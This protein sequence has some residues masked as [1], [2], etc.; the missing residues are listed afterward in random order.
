M[1]TKWF[2]NLGSES[3]SNPRRLGSGGSQEG[4][5]GWISAF[6][7]P[8]SS[9]MGCNFSL[10]EKREPLVK[11]FRSQRSLCGYGWFVEYPVKGPKLSKHIHTIKTSYII[12]AAQRKTEV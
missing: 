6:K 10:Q 2:S 7:A 8:F 4:R 11:S 3:W 9:T 1:D 12:C 5:R